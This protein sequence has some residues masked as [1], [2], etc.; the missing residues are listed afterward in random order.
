MERNI[1]SEELF[2]VASSLARSYGFISSNEIKE[3]HKNTFQETKP[4][5]NVNNK[6]KDSQKDIAS[7]IK[8]Y[9][10]NQLEVEGGP[11][12]AFHSTV[13]KDTRPST[14]TAKKPVDA[15]FTLSIVGVKDPFA[16]ALLITCAHH[17][18]SKLKVKE[19][20]IRLNSIGDKV[21]AQKYLSACKKTVRKNKIKLSRECLREVE[22]DIIE[23]HPL[24]FE[25]KNSE[26][27]E[28]IQVSLRFLSEQAN[29]HFRNV[30]EYLDTHNL[31][32]EL[33]PELIEDPN[34][35]CDT[36]FELLSEDTDLHAK[37]GRYD[38]LTN[39]L[40]RKDLPVTSI[41]ITV[42]EKTLGSQKEK[43]VIKTPKLFFFHSGT[44]ARLNSLP[45]LTELIDSNIPVKHKLH[46]KEVETQLND[47]GRDFPFILILG[48]DEVEEKVL[49]IRK[50]DTRAIEL[51]KREEGINTIKAYLRNS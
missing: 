6:P 7:I 46:C 28:Q 27:G 29:S 20:T 49:R 13:S 3:V 48:Q 45:L 4:K 30:I 47:G 33:V 14:S 43:K 36:I 10:E 12:F 1:S 34:Y 16:E 35:C 11:I 40:F 5:I 41:T 50:N 22:K 19:T 9:L 37:G 21:S 17:I 18:F 2:N 31:N 8:F 42:P 23:A 51:I 39:H 38:N 32:Y 24:L 44:T 15:S 25:E 26:I